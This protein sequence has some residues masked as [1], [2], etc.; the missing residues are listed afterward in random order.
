MVRS[1]FSLFHKLSYLCLLCCSICRSHTHSHFSVSLFFFFFCTLLTS[2]W[3]AQLVTS[4]SVLPLQFSLLFSFFFCCFFPS[5]LSSSCDGVSQRRELHL[6]STKRSRIGQVIDSITGF[7]L[8]VFFLICDFFFYIL[9]IKTALKLLTYVARKIET[10]NISQCLR[11]VSVFELH[12]NGC[13]SG[14]CR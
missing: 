10:A 14:Y 9:K 7:L 3:T 8:F 2:E 13:T 6:D 5:F 12:K 4:V 11:K 1:R